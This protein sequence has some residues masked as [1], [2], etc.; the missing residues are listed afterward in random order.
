MK[1]KIYQI[2]PSFLQNLLVTLYNILA[3]RHRYG[4]K[5]R[6]Y[7]ARYKHNEN[8]TLEELKVIQKERYRRFMEYTVEHSS[9]YKRELGSIV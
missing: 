5:Y 4:G 1:D 7:L 3:Y 9:F 8:L 2:L 6:E